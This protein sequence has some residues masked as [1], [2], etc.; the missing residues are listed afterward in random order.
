MDVG[1]I[2]GGLAGAG[3]LTLIG[4]LVRLMMAD[5]SWRNM[6]KEKQD[7]YIACQAR[8]AVLEAENLQK[9]N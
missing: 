6:F 4:T 8:A 5:Q 9:K 1:I 7:E 2:G 3:M